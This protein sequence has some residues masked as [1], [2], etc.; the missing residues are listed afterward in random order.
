MREAE[1]VIVVDL[2]PLERQ[3]LLLLLSQLEPEDWHKPTIY[4][5]W[6]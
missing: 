4:P 6:Q 1:P 3:E 2:F 5:E